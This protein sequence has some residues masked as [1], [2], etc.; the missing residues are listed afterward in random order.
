MKR[1]F[2]E[3]DSQSL[4][5]AIKI[6]ENTVEDYDIIVAVRWNGTINEVAR[7]LVNKGEGVY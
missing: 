6:A 7:G 4:R 5:E 2:N 1:I 3:I